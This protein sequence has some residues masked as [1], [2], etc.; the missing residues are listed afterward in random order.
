[1]LDFQILEELIRFL[2]TKKY[3]PQIFVILNIVELKGCG[4]LIGLLLEN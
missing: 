1:M 2:R 3:R 4:N